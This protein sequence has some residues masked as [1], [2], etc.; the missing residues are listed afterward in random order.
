MGYGY[1]VKDSSDP[2]V[3]TARKLVQMTAETIHPGALLVNDL[4]FCEC[5]L[6]IREFLCSLFITPVKY[7]PES[8]SWLSYKPLT[9]YGQNLGQ[10]A[11]HGPM[12]FVK[13]SIVSIWAFQEMFGGSQI[14][15]STALPNHHLLSKICK[16][17][18]NWGDQSVK[19]WKE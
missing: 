4:P 16:R 1:E 12:E 2:K 18:R 11:L 14:A 5:S 6:C 19:G 15:S 13:E 9:R 7:I 3:K 17:Q 8:L 10:E